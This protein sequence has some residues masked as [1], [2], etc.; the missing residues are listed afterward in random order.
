MPFAA[1]AATKA[2][3]LARYAL[4]RGCAEAKAEGEV[5]RESRGESLMRRT[6]LEVGVGEWEGEGVGDMLPLPLLEPLGEGVE[7][8]EGR[9]EGVVVHT[10]RHRTVA[11]A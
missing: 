3:T 9:G 1:K 4:D 10:P 8:L 7:D 2:A 5:V 11:Y 6:L